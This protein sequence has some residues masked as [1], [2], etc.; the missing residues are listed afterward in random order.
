MVKGPMYAKY[1]VGN[2]HILKCYPPVCVLK[3]D[4]W[5]H[6]LLYL[7]VYGDFLKLGVTTYNIK[8]TSFNHF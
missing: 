6:L 8:I 2:G 1:V 4:R 7:F 5:Q 3:P